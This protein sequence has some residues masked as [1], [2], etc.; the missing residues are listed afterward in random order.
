MRVTI[1]RGFLLAAATVLTLASAQ[2]QAPAAG[3]A[4]GGG[5][6]PSAAQPTKPQ[7]MAPPGTPAGQTTDGRQAR[8]AA[9]TAVI[10]KTGTPGG[11]VPGNTGGADSGVK[12]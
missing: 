10:S 5:V 4:G 11:A 12:K 8:D 2:A 6:A 7:G 9:G 3:S 1:Y